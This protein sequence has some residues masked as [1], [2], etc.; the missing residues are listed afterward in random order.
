MTVGALKRQDTTPINPA[1]QAQSGVGL[2]I[3]ASQR[4]IACRVT[5]DAARMHE[6]L[7]RFRESCLRRRRVS[8]LERIRCRVL[9]RE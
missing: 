1:A 9:R 2:T 4:R 5:I 3:F 6:D 8:R 7:I